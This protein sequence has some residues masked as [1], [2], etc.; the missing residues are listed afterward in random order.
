MSRAGPV[1]LRRTGLTDRTT[2]S[3]VGNI[4]ARLVALVS[5]TIVTVIVAR[6]GGAEDVGLLALMRV[7]PGFVGVVAACGLPGAMGYFVA[8]GDAAHPRLWPTISTLMLAGALLGTAAWL[9]L[10]PLIHDRLMATTTYAVVAVTGLTVATQLPVAVGKSCLQALDDARGSNVVTAAEEAAF[11]PAYLVLWVAGSRGGWLLVLSLLVADVVVAAY[12]W[13]RIARRVRARA[14]QRSRRRARLLGRPD[15]LL[16]RRMVGFGL[17]GQVGGILSLLNLRLDVVIL[18]ALTGPA[19]VGVYVVASKYAE[20]LRLPGLALN[21]VTY[22]TFSRSA[23][24]ASTTSDGT[25]PSASGRQHPRLWRLL[26]LGVVSGVLLAASAF[27]VLPLVYGEQFRAAAPPA[28]WI[29]L[30]LV[31]GP[32]AGVASGYLLGAGRPGL[33]SAIL[34]GGFLVTLVLDVLLIPRHGSLGAAW[35][36]MVAYLTTDLLLVQAWR[37]LSREPS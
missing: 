21:W 19:Q 28:A 29:S 16:A 33:N 37:H 23:A 18:G 17:R 11:V 30:G 34:G 15:R 20:L 32:A 1:L 2:R 31:V 25:E 12:A 14:R 35:A 26:A 36:S 3:V 5:V 4:G 9:L 10:T 8:G 6:A 24:L 13:S 7:L 27:V 22:P